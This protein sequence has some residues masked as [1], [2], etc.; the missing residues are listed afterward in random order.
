M[1]ISLE[2]FR[3]DGRKTIRY[4]TVVMAGVNEWLTRVRAF[5]TL[6]EVQCLL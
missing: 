6:Q 2:T 4:T 3:V 1:C 5:D